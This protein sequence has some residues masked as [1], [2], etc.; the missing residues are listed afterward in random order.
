M[1]TCEYDG[2]PF[3]EPRSHPWTDAVTSAAFRYYD[4]R[5]TPSLIRTALEDFVPF[6][7]HA[8][9][10]RFYALLE[11]LNG[12]DS[13]FE[14]SDCAFTAPHAN[15]TADRARAFECSGRIIVLFRDLPLNASP[16]DVAW[17]TG[18]LHRDLSE[19]DALFELGV[20]GT[21][22]VPA[23]YLA[24]PPA[25]QLGE[26]LMISFWAWGSAEADLMGNLERVIANLSASLRH[27]SK[28]V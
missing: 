27:V 21:T 25:E 5:A 3:T 11:W 20:I 2:P 17:L 10:T 4:L 6:G 22:R 13:P 8:A 16:P 9:V 24:L 12:D 18:A 26:Q 14:S 1:R 19:R 7:D 23:R 15:G 28:E